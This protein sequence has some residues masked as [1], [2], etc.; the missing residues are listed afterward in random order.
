MDMGHINREKKEKTRIYPVMTFFL[1]V[2]LLTGLFSAC[3][4]EHAGLGTIDDHGSNG[5][6]SPVEGHEGET[7][8]TAAMEPLPWVS[9]LSSPFMI[10]EII[11]VD[12]EPFYRS[13]DSIT[14]SDIV[15]V[16]ALCNVLFSYRA[17]WADRFDTAGNESPQGDIG[18]KLVELLISEKTVSEWNDIK[19]VLV[20][21]KEQRINSGVYASAAIGSNGVARFVEI[22]ESGLE[23]SKAEEIPYPLEQ[24]NYEI[25]KRKPKNELP[26][27]I[28]SM[29]DKELCDGM[30]LDE[31]EQ[32]FAAWEET[33]ELYDAAFRKL[34]GYA[35]S[36][37]T[38]TPELS[39]AQWYYDAQRP[40]AI[41]EISE[42]SDEH[43]FFGIGDERIFIREY[44]NGEYVYY[45][46][47]P[48]KILYSHGIAAM[49]GEAAE[50]PAIYGVTSETF[51]ELTELNILENV[52]SDIKQVGAALI[53]LTTQLWSVGLGT[54]EAPDYVDYYF[55]SAEPFYDY[56]P[57]DQ[58]GLELSSDNRNFSDLKKL[59]DVIESYAN[60]EKTHSYEYAIPDKT[61][62]DGMSIEEIKQWF[63][64]WDKAVELYSEYFES[65]R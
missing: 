31:V 24:L 18:G 37:T 62:S 36:N 59:N 43:V 23:L 21:V 13:W 49:L 45:V 33:K 14:R 20:G 15:Y 27:Y 56:F 9:Y 28:E 26:D 41:V 44:I 46:K 55:I 51:D 17:S 11:S 30:T 61:L 35:G 48:C 3:Q 58:N 65:I 60:K 5:F 22:S 42:V 1:A 57:I 53:P 29:P 54:E 34:S 40:Y 12:T 6:G 64:A 4:G 2:L 25:R 7:Q 47:A 52:A 8:R 10:V 38:P 50:D 39:Y 63:D 32:W 16:K 19:T